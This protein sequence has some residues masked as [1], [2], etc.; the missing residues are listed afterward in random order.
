MT[1]FLT[2][3]RLDIRTRTQPHSS[4]K[5]D[6]FTDLQL[7]AEMRQKQLQQRK[8]AERQLEQQHATR[9]AEIWGSEHM[10]GDTTRNSWEKRNVTK[11]CNNTRCT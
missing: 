3:Q 2:M 7:Q 11:V 6:Y 5:H 8:E 9:V 1:W 10:K 4:N